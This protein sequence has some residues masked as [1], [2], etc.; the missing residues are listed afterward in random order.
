MA[1]YALGDNSALP[2]LGAGAIGVLGGVGM[3]STGLYQESRE[4]SCFEEKTGAP[5]PESSRAQRTK[6]KFSIHSVFLID[7]V[8]DTDGYSLGWFLSGQSLLEIDILNRGG[9]STK[10]ERI[11]FNSKQTGGA[12]FGIVSQV[13][14]F[15][16]D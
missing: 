16:M 15:T 12:F 7:A 14:V 11:Q 6:K 10:G 3:V 1:V 13:I 4:H 5:H 2:A 8:A 9:Q